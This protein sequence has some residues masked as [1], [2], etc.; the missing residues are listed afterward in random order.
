[1]LP[2]QP[3]QSLMNG[4]ECLRRIAE[5]AEPVGSRELARRMGVGHATVNRLLNTLAHLHYLE[6]TPERKFSP[7][8]GLYVLNAHGMH[9]SRLLRTA[10]PVL[11]KLGEEHR[12]R[13]ALGVVWNNQV[14]Y[15]F[16]E[17]PQVD[18]LKGLLGHDPLPVEKS[19]IG[20]LL[21]T[22]QSETSDSQMEW[23]N[24]EEWHAIRRDRYAMWNP[25]SP[26]MSVACPV[27]SGT[28]AAVALS[29]TTQQPIQADE[30]IARAREIADQIN[31]DFKN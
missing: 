17:D 11:R 29:S 12:Y 28:T 26:S 27:G 15:L 3:N 22:F 13:I 23:L 6:K 19:S 20:R 31:R 4:L 5:S 1:M 21:K 10:L 9:N 16:F 8:P 14:S 18:F 30:L 24:Q 25:N 2:S 7:G